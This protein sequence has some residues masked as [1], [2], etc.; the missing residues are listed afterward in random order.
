MF[1]GVTS[2]ALLYTRV[3]SLILI[4][5]DAP[6]VQFCSSPKKKMLSRLPRLYQRT[7]AMSTTANVW[8]NKDTR[9]IV[10]GF[11]GKQVC[12]FDLVF[13]PLLNYIILF[14][15]FIY[16]I[17]CFFL[18]FLSSFLPFF[19]SSFLPFFFSLLSSFFHCPLFTFHTSHFAIVFFPPSLSFIH[20]FFLSL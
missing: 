9:C 14:N 11:T 4:T 19:L 15:I 8:V 2:F 12:H 20:S 7:R 5:A 13:L 18:F 10:Q 6:T 17:C 3:T 16:L 1:Q